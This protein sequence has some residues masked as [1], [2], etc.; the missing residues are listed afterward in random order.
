MIYKA[1]AKIN[2]GLD[3]LSKRS[4]G[5]HTLESLFVPLPFY[6]L[7]EFRE[8]TSFSLSNTG[9]TVDCAPHE[10]L[11]YKTWEALHKRYNIPPI[12]LHLHKQIPYGA[13]LG[14]GSSDATTLLMA[15]NN[16]FSLSLLRQD[17]H[18]IAQ[19]LGSDC[20]FFLFE[21]PMFTKGTGNEF[22][23]APVDLSDL[24]YALYV[25][26]IPIS[27]PWAYKQIKPQKPASPL[28]ERLLLPM[29]QWQKQIE[30]DFEEAV[31]THYPQIRQL[32]SALIDAGA[33]YVSLS[34]SGS[35]VFALSKTPINTGML[36]NTPLLSHGK[37]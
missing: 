36:H 1:P 5:Y 20:P 18:E 7:I 33:D 17:L 13:G 15:L 27:T 10:N 2:V 28:K 26:N 16:Q 14:G 23:P 35:A 37:L 25:P 6:D 34:G 12:E 3:I 31:F 9:I 32:K 22:E 11:L 19:S 4:D 8:A 24:Y 21:S 30:N 29:E